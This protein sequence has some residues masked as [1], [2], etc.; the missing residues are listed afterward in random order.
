VGESA[1]P[2][3]SPTAATVPPLPE[4]GGYS[5]DD[6]FCDSTLRLRAEWRHCRRYPGFI[7][8]W[9]KSLVLNLWSSFYSPDF[10]CL[11]GT[12]WQC[13]EVCYRIIP[14]IFCAGLRAAFKSPAREGRD[15]MRLQRVG[16]SYRR[17]RRMRERVCNLW[18][19][20]K[21]WIY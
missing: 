14:I 15:T 20:L 17:R 3:P 18:M 2:R 4:G 5:L 13:W 16:S 1:L 8:E 7:K 6:G 10:N 21:D 11:W 9:R 12:R 19:Y